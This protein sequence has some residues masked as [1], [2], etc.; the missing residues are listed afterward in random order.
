MFKTIN[1]EPTTTCKALW[2]IGVLTVSDRVARGQAIDHSGPEVLGIV[3]EQ[4]RILMNGQPGIDSSKLRFNTTYKVVADEIDNIRAVVRGWIGAGY[5]LVLT[6]G[7]TGFAPRDVT[8]EAIEPLIT[9][10]TPGIVV[11]M[12]KASLEITPHAMLSRPVAGIAE[13]TL[14]VTLP[15]SVKGSRE[16]LRATK[17]TISNSINNK[18]V[19]QHHLL[20]LIAT[21]TL[22]EVQIASV[23]LLF[24][25]YTP[26]DE[27]IR[28]ILEQ[29]DGVEKRTE[30]VAIED[31]L[32]MVVA[33][34]IVSGVAFPSFRASI[35]D[36]FAV[37]S[38]DGV[39]H[40]TVL[41]NSLAGGGD[42]AKITQDNIKEKTCV[43]ITTG[44]MIPD[45]F[46]AIVMVEDTEPVPSTDGREIVSIE[47]S[48]A[49]GVDVRPIGSDI[50]SG[51]TILKRG[52]SIGAAEI[53]LLAT[54]GHTTVLVH[55]PPIITIISTGDELVTYDTKDVEE[56]YIRDSNSPTL[57]CI[58]KEISNHF[59]ECGGKN[60]HV[61]GIV[62]DKIDKLEEVL[63][64][65]AASSDVIITSGGVSMGQLDLVKPLLGKIGKVHFGRVNMKPGKPLTFATIESNNNKR[66]LVFALPGNP[67][68]TMVTFYLFATP[69]L[70]K[71][72]GHSTLTLPLV[73]T[74]LGERIRMDPERPEYHRCL[75]SWNMEQHCFVSAST[76]SQASCRL[77][78]MKK[79]NALLL[80][81]QREGYLEKGTTVKAMI[82]GP[83]C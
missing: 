55:K 77:L 53:G 13:S 44:A 26:V 81:P 79:S 27:A 47:V 51:D 82:I 15:G 19:H 80:L 68:S 61:H 33:E 74:K 39:G 67:V 11:A 7:G 17:Q 35:K 32:G 43:R 56:G 22:V 10:K 24:L 1:F 70:R 58:V 41:A 62:A 34:D 45:G 71:L 50:K 52:E 73:E 30:S 48:V 9:R 31:A 2:D 36:G 60:V 42:A 20:I 21:L 38:Q 40:Y 64:S 18:K 46:D 23:A 63:R 57:K 4:L 14:I 76:G 16:N 66:T 59:G 12:L 6:T 83:L 3:K 65:A 28:I 8:P 29:C 54:L 25:W 5:K 78:S 69:A 49:P 37:R 72:S 75:V